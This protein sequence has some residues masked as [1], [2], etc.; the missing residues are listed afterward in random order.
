MGWQ[1]VIRSMAAAERRSRRAHA[2]YARQQERA[3]MRRRRELLAQQAAQNELAHAQHQ[4][5]LFENYLELLVSV[6]KDCSDPW[7][8]DR[9]VVQPRPS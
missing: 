4:V 7:R 1:G 9:I 3:A 2:A 6:H 5:Q 8:W